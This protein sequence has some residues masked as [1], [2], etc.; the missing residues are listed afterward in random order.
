MVAVKLIIVESVAVEL[1]DFV[2]LNSD[3]VH[4][5]HKYSLRGLHLSKIQ[6]SLKIHLI[7]IC[8]TSLMNIHEYDDCC[9]YVT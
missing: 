3:C 1:V 9:H 4:E 7:L 6:K 5:I 8:V 2:V